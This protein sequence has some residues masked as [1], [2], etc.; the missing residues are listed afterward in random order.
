ML[1]GQK[2]HEARD[3][4]KGKK[5]TDGER[6]WLWFLDVIHTEKSF[7]NL[8]KSNRNKIVLTIFRLIWNQ[9]EDR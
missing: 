2:T 7:R 4:R 5:T 6:R 3:T 9:T 8:I 1:M